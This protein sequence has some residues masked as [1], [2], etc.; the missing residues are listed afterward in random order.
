[1]DR[2]ASTPRECPNVHTRSR[3]DALRKGAARVTSGRNTGPWAAF[4]S[5]G[6]GLKACDSAV[7]Y[8]T[9]E[10][11]TQPQLLPEAVQLVQTEIRKVAEEGVT[12]DEL[13]RARMQ[14]RGQ[15]LLA[16][17]ALH[18]RMSRLATQEFYFGRFIEESEVIAAIDGLDLEN[19]HEVAEAVLETDFAIAVVGPESDETTTEQIVEVL[20]GH[21][22]VA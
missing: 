18:T 11:V 7:A 12:E 2:C 6:L 16:A 17:D 4:I 5:S 19:V 20:A 13:W 21:K 8:L 9:V 15:H 1:M 22:A 10:G 3:A 14:L